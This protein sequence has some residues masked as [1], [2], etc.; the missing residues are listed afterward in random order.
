ML[1]Q[2]SKLNHH[3][4]SL[5]LPSPSPSSR[6][7]FFHDFLISLSTWQLA[8]TRVRDSFPYV[9]TSS[10]DTSHHHRDPSRLSPG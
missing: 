6:A 7:N 2:V 10:L 3:H 5:R 8:N 4:P 9:A 1:S